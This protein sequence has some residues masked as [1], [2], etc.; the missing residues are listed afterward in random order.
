M[1]RSAGVVGDDKLGCRERLE[2]LSLLCCCGRPTGI[3]DCDGPSSSSLVT[4]PWSETCRGSL[5]GEDYISEEDH[6]TVQVSGYPSYNN[7]L[8][9]GRCQNVSRF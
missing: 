3:P 1:D 9:M 7:V 5:R 8:V 6:N 2:I 4:G